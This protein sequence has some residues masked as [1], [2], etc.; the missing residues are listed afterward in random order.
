MKVLLINPWEAEVF[1]PP[2]I[3]YLQS[4]LRHWKV[5][6]EAMDLK[7][8]KDAKDH[9]DIVGVSFHSFSVRH[10]RA[11]RE[12]FKGSHLICGGHHP[13][14][15]PEQMLEEGYDQVVV[16]EGE[17]AI[18]SII[19]GNTDKIIYDWK[20]DSHYFHS[21]NDL[22]LPDYS[23]LYYT[24]EMGFPVISSRGC[25]FRCNFCASANFWHNNTKLRNASNVLWEIEALI[26][27]G[28]NSWMFE[29]DNFT[30]KRSRAIE[31]C[32]GIVAMNKKV[33]WQATSRA[34]ALIDNDLCYHLARAGCHTVWLGIE[35]LSQKSLD[36]CEKN[37]TVEK[38]IKG[39]NNAKKYGLSTRCQFIAGLPGDSVKDIEET[40]RLM[41]ANNIHAGANIL[42][43]L[44]F[45]RAWKLA[46]QRG[47]HDE[48]F[49]RG[50]SLYY[51]YEQD[52][53]TLQ[54]WARMIGTA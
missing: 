28:I 25:P 5:D 20:V 35:S 3:G 23:G 10:A 33:S 37:T 21:I 13:S 52:I 40:V 34:E 16:G 9:Y 6:V 53:N 29:D 22:P 48:D 41:K 51:T 14:A 49:L 2:S 15:L 27:S 43:I 38:M 42:W 30:L 8:A 47:W 44:P 7:Q 32:E 4:A 50:C 31:I 26:S 45:T 39:I 12:I 36:R 18:I 17:N 54:T 24:A 1:P 11:I 46:K 19:Q